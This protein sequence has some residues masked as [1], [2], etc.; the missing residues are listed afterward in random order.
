MKNDS[1]TINEK[2][3]TVGGIEFYYFTEPVK[4]FLPG[5]VNLSI[6]DDKGNSRSMVWN[7]DKITIEKTIEGILESKRWP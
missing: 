4:N 1:N 6:R 5:Y 7:P 2:Q 3:V